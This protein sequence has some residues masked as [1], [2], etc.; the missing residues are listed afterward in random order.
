MVEERDLDDKLEDKATNEVVDDVKKAAME[1]VDKEK[2]QVAMKVANTSCLVQLWLLIRRAFKFVEKRSAASAPV[3][4]TLPLVQC[5]S[6]PVAFSQFFYFL[7][8]FHCTTAVLVEPHE[9]VKWV[10]LKVDTL[11][12]IKKRTFYGQANRKHPPS[13]HPPAIPIFCKF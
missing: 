2:K 7:H 10:D 13:P 1:G 11:L 3:I 8:H 6:S 12:V 4:I 9:S 5:Y